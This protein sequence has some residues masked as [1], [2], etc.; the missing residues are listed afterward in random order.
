[1]NEC[2]ACGQE[3]DTSLPRGAAGTWLEAVRLQ[4]CP[5]LPDR[6]LWLAQS[7]EH[8]PPGVIVEIRDD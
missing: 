1:M 4:T 5:N 2:P 3:H 6:W 8:G 7:F